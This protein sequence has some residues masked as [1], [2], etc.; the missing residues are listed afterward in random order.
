MNVF[1]IFLPLSQKSVTK[2]AH[3]SGII[4]EN[5]T[6]FYRKLPVAPSVCVAVEFKLYAEQT[7]LKLEDPELFPKLGRY[8]RPE[9]Y[10]VLSDSDGL[11]L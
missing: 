4:T 11:H 8:L 9:K 1:K 2:S 7:Y 3:V 5:V 10:V 6:F